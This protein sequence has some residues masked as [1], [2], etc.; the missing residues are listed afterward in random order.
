MLKSQT[1]IKEC[2]VVANGLV[3]HFTLRNVGPGTNMSD[4]NTAQD[5]NSETLIFSHGEMG[6]SSIHKLKKC[7]T[8]WVLSLK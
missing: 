1:I 8:L 3:T 6:S 4:T 7:T 2:T 5:V